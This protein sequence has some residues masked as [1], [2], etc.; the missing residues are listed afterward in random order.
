M[1]IQVEK[2][3]KRQRSKSQDK[4]KPNNDTKTCAVKDSKKD[5]IHRQA[6]RVIQLINSIKMDTDKNKQN[7]TF[8]DGTVEKTTFT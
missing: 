7:D 1:A 3:T 2:N 6:N 4:I 8:Y 5:K